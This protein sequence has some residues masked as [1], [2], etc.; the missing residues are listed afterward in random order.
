V[1]EGAR[2]IAHFRKGAAAAE[3][4]V[5]ELP[6]CIALQADLANEADVDRLFADAEAKLGAVSVLIA[7]AGHWPTEPTP[8]KDLSLARWR[9]TIDDNLTSAF[10][11]M[12]AFLRGVERHKIAEPSAV[13]IGSTAGTFGEAGHGDYAAVKAG[14]NFGFTKTLKNEV[15]RMAPRGRVNVVA[16]GWTV[17]PDK[18]TAMMANPDGVRRTL[19]T[20]PLRKLARPEDVAAA[21]VFLS[22]P[23]LAGHLT[24]EIMT[25]SGGMEG[26]V[27]FRPEEIEL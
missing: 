9:S 4:L 26:R 21:C 15:A 24:G 27:L 19:Q 7:N 2:V 6:G 13:F 12:R 14:L 20:L 10:L 22:S 18:E 8:I 3:R 5:R 23:K 17:T 11:S 25:V 16:P 1:G